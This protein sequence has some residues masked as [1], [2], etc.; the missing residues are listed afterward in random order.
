[1]IKS[2]NKI[3]R[4]QIATKLSVS[5]RTVQRMLNSIEGLTYIGSGRGGHW[6]Y[7]ADQ[8]KKGNDPV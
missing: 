1:M 8:I 3:T 2:N 7:D 5:L 6:E 4:K